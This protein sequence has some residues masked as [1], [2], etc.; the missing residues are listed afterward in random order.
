[1]RRLTKTLPGKFAERSANFRNQQTCRKQMSLILK[2]LSC[3]GSL[4]ADVCGERPQSSVFTN[5]STSYLAPYV[6][7]RTPSYYVGEGAYAP[8]LLRGGLPGV[9]GVLEVGR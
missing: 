3:F 7:M 5:E 9:G 8:S 4:H 1:M 2:D 6:C